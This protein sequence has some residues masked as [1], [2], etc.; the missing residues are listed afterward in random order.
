MAKPTGLS[1]STIR[2]RIRAV[3]DRLGRSTMP[4]TTR[5]IKLRLRE[6]GIQSPGFFPVKAHT[7]FVVRTANAIATVLVRRGIRIDRG[8][9]VQSARAHDSFRDS[10]AAQ[11][12]VSKRYWAGKG[13]PGVARVIGT[14]ESWTLRN[15]PK[16]TL[17]RKVMTYADH[18][19]RGVKV[20]NSFMN[21]VVPSGTSFRLLVSQRQADPKRVDAL[22]REHLAVVKFE[23]EL[24]DMGVDLKSLFRELMKRNP[25]SFAQQVEK[26]IDPKVDEIISASMKRL[27]IRKMDPGFI[28]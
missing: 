4:N 23:R 14:G 24:E 27:G 25:R 28:I 12:Q 6:M 5:R 8:L 13:A 26:S 20:G 1:P 18:T 15:H 11:D 21:G 3:E 7:R 10:G 2:R 9:T 22:V 16:W 19:G 17:E